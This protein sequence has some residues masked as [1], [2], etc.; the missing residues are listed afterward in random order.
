MS[1][2][3]QRVVAAPDGS[4]D[5]LFNRELSYEKN[6]SSQCPQA[7]THSRFSGTDGHEGRSASVEPAPREGQKTPFRLDHRASDWANMQRALD[8]TNLNDCSMRKTT[9]GFL[10]NPRCEPLINTCCCWENVMTGMYTAWVWS[11]PKKTFG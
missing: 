5:S 4:H 6:I 9:A 8:S 1:R 11:S 2:Y 3:P 7:Q 10:T